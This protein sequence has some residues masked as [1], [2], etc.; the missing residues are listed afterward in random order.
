MYVC[1]GNYNA[2]P[3]EG[4]C[5]GCRPRLHIE[6]LIWPLPGHVLPVCHQT[7]AGSGGSNGNAHCVRIAKLHPDRG[8]GF[9][10]Y[11]AERPQMAKGMS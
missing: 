8:G 10:F 9:A 2:L 4:S 7:L 5:C 6:V 3:R 11:D 1:E